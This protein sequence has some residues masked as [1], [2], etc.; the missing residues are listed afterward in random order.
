MKEVTSAS[1]LSTELKTTKSKLVLL[2]FFAPWCGPC[3]TL[4]PILEQLSIKYPSV[5]F[6]KINADTLSDLAEEYAVSALPTIV[7]MKKGATKWEKVAIIKGCQPAAIEKA[8]QQ[9]N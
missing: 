7:I 8:I 6:L 4:L 9:Y 1:G 3:K 2:D 5:L